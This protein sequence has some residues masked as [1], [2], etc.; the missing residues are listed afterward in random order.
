MDLQVEL[1]KPKAQ[2]F[3]RELNKVVDVDV[4]Q[5]TIMVDG[6]GLGY[7]CQAEGLPINW[8]PVA[9]AY[10]RETLDQLEVKVNAE[11]VKLHGETAGGR[12]ATPP[13]SQ[14]SVDEAIEIAAKMAEQENSVDGPD[15]DNL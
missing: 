2:E 13:L 4:K 3:N 1:I 11:L 7:V 15:Q 9:N 10:S 8:L 5:Y 6:K 14:E 12:S